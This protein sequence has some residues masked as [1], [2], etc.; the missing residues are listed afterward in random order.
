MAISSDLGRVFEVDEPPHHK[1]QPFAY[2][3]RKKDE[4]DLALFLQSSFHSFFHQVGP[5]FRAEKSRTSRHLCEF[6]GLDLEM[7]IDEHY[8]EVCVCIHVLVMYDAS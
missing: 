5:V 7:G 1:L 3:K 6:T 4:C 8:D 2:T